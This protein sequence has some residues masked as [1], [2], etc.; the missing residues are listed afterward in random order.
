MLVGEKLGDRLFLVRSRARE[1]SGRCQNI[2]RTEEE[3]R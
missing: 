1:E 3:L 2:P